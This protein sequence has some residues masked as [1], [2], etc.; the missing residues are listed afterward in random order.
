MI[1][2]KDKRRGKLW[3]PM[4][5]AGIFNP[6]LALAAV[7]LLGSILVSAPVPAQSQGTE[8]ISL[9]P[10][11][12]SAGNS[13]GTDLTGDATAGDEADQHAGYYYPKPKT[14]ERYTS[15]APTLPDSDKVRREGFVIGLTKQLLGG[16]YAPYY[17]IFAKGNQ[18]DKLII[19]GLVDGQLDTIYRARALLATLT[20]V[21]RAT[22]FFQQSTHPEEATFFD[23]M[24]LLGFR[25]ITL[26]D[27]KSFAHQISID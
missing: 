8:T 6:L 4:S 5:D 17:A 19:V 20:S 9:T 7:A 3:M 1:R 11:Q 27:G 13:A 12:P 2:T 23:L 21:A 24:K 15:S 10:P 26:T 22:N 25:R 16:Q 18:A 14:F